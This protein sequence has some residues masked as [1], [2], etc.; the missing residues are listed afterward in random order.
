M[1]LRL[2][3][4]DASFKIT[5]LASELRNFVANV[6]R[7]WV[8]SIELRPVSPV[9]AVGV[10][11]AGVPNLSRK[12]NFPARDGG[13][14]VVDVASNEAVDTT[15]IAGG[16]QKDAL[17]PPHGR[18]TLPESGCNLAPCQPTLLHDASKVA[19]ASPGNFRRVRD[20]SAL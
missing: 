14:Q 11:G 13:D 17:D 6:A 1:Y 3:L 7:E 15:V 8:R 4:S 12:M 5:L 20:R 16:S 2:E 19:R 10:V 9:V 18:N